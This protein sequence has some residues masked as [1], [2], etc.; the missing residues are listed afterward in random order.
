[1]GANTG[2]YL[3]AAARTLVFDACLIV[4]E[5]TSRFPEDDAIHE[6]LELLGAHVTYITQEGQFTFTD[7]LRT[8]RDP[9][10]KS[11]LL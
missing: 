2:D 10:T 6:R 5:A 7:A 8:D 9:Y 1:M 4:C 3:R 11:S